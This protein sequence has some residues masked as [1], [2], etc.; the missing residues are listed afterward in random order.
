[1]KKEAKK[2]VVYITKNALTKG[3]YSKEVSFC[4]NENFV[5]YIDRTISL[6]SD[7][8]VVFRPGE[9]ELTLEKANEFAEIMRMK[10]MKTLQRSFLL[11]QNKIDKLNL[12]K[13]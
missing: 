13:F 2:F 6:N 3:I 5:Y 12:L 9:W 11:T 10:K 8:Q 1:M 4:P 7:G